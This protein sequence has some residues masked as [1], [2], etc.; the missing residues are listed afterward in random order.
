MMIDASRTRRDHDTESAERHALLAAFA[1]FQGSS[2]R[3]SIVQLTSTGLAYLTTLAV[4]Y[5]AFPVS[6]WLILTLSPLAAGSMIR[7]FIIQ[8]DCGHGSYFHSR[9]ANKIAGRLCSLATF[10]PYDNWRRQHANHHGIWNNLDRRDSGA[11][12]YSTCLTLDEYV[13]LP[14]HRQRIYR[15]ARH[16]LIAQLLLPPMVFLLLYRMPF[17]T[18]KAWRVERRSVHLT[19]LALAAMLGGSAILFGWRAV[20]LVHLPIVVLA[21]IAGVWLFSVQHRFESA[22]WLRQADWS[23]VRASLNGSSYLKLPRIL[24]WFTGNIGF[25]HI[26][27]LLPQVPNYRLESCH[28]ALLARSVPVKTLSFGESLHAP[29]YA[30]WDEMNGRMVRFPHIPSTMPP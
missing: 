8:H 3:C 20:L 15:A 24:Q 14:A 12:I 11:D 13:A 23:P 4:M 27:H 10:T 30:L 29:G 21:S 25:H 7:L 18:P 28:R 2:P 5:A 1:P 17:D 26:H 6:G 9:H 16:P 19:N 22:E